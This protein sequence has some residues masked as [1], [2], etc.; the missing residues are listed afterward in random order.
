MFFGGEVLGGS[1][2]LV[3]G[4]V[5]FPP[6][7]LVLCIQIVAVLEE[8]RGFNFSRQA[9]GK[10]IWFHLALDLKIV[11]QRLFCRQKL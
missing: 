4:W 2:G 5:F 1:L 9:K 11:R 8:M 6:S 3:F 10:K 7:L